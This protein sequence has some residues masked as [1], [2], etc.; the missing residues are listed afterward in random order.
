MDLVTLLRKI[1]SIPS[2]SHEE[3][4]VADF[5]CGIIEKDGFS[6]DRIYN[7]IIVPSPGNKE[8]RPHLM[9]CTHIDTV[10]AGAGY[11]FDPFAPPVSS[12][13][14]FG[15]GS[16]DAGGCVVAMYQA[17][18]DIQKGSALPF[19]LSLVLTAEEE[20]S[21]PKGIEC[22]R[23][24]ISDRFDFAIIGEPTAMRGAVAERG[25]LVV[26]AQAK[27]VAGHAARNEGINAIDIAIED[28]AVLKSLG[29][30]ATVTQI[31]AGVQHNVIPD[32][33]SWVIDIRTEGGQ[34]NEKI[35]KTLSEKLQ[36]SLKARSLK[37]KS[38]ATPPEHV[39]LKALEMEGVVQ[40]VSPT[41]SD[42]MRCPVPAIKIGPG[43]SSRSHRNDE[44][45]YI[46]E[47]NEGVAGYT[48]LL[49]NLAQLTK[50][51]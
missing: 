16:N 8:G 10:M 11:T 6:F 4:A 28:I 9:M 33:C 5:L 1:V 43:E 22:L 49:N 19:N 32:L 27:G 36:S 40:Y 7:N 42:W 26:D 30:K 41:T 51:G 21:G 50:N 25:L 47:I 14:V 17:F 24:I 38:S 39:L 13:K 29:Y 3:E 18:K 23:G 15:L 46:E 34:S 31:N 48:R 44:Y 12:E 20:C 45:I 37:N 2:P 35:M